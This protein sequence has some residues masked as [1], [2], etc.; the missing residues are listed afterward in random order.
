MY[1]QPLFSVSVAVAV[2]QILTSKRDFNSNSNRACTF[3]HFSSVSVAVAV[4]QILNSKRDFNSNRDLSLL[5]RLTQVQ[6]KCNTSATETEKKVAES[7]NSIDSLN[8]F[9]NIQVSY[10]YLG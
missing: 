3:S 1:F 2:A 7:M 10:H 5:K 8:S 4:A 6:H 9:A